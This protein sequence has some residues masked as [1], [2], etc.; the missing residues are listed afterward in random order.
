MDSCC[1]IHGQF[2]HGKSMEGL[3]KSWTVYGNF[4][5][6]SGTVPEKFLESSRTLS[7][8]F[9]ETSIKVPWKVP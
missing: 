4:P 2:L 7:G 5:E 3:A 9:M 8:N 1:Q 6:S